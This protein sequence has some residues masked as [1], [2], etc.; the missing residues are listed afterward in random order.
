MGK[1]KRGNYIF[2]SWK[3]DHGHHVHVY[4]DGKQVVKWDIENWDAMTGSANRR[5]IRIIEELLSEG[6]FED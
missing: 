5:I 2:M 1:V 4:K 6:A 3:G